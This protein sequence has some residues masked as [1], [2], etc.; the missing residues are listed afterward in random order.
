MWVEE[1]GGLDN[2]L[3]TVLKV[4]VVYVID[5]AQK[6]AMAMVVVGCLVA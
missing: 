5:G 1:A 2:C 4:I 3:G 6:L